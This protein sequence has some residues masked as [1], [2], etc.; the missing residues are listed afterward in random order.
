[1]SSLEQAQSAQE[2]LDTAAKVKELAKKGENRVW[3]PNAIPVKGRPFIE[4]RRRLSKRQN[5]ILD[6][7]FIP[8]ML[9]HPTPKAHYGWASFQGASKFI[10]VNRAAMG[11]YRYVKPE[12]LKP[13][14]A[15]AFEVQ[16]GTTGTMVRHGSMVLVEIPD[17]AWLECFVEPEI[18]SV[19]RLAD[20]EEYFQAQIE[21]ASE[22]S[23]KGTVERKKETEVLE[24]GE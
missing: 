23:A 7:A 2:A 24:S 14:M 21:E 8:T 3:M 17:E 6:S 19:A 13:E 10:T 11:Q 16:K 5:Q 22:G 1:M 9:K 20:R 15:A 18:E 12:E 4:A